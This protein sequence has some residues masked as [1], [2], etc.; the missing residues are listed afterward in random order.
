MDIVTKKTEGCSPDGSNILSLFKAWLIYLIR[1]SR[2][3]H[4]C[5]EAVVAATCITTPEGVG[6]SQS[7]LM[8][9]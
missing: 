6:V 8:F 3:L 5:M 1:Y 7:L 4:S 9:L 2:R